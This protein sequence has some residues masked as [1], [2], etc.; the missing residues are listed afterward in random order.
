MCLNLF[1][2][3]DFCLNLL[4]RLKVPEKVTCIL[5]H[6]MVLAW[7]AEVFLR[8]KV[9]EVS[10]ASGSPP[11]LL[12]LHFSPT[13]QPKPPHLKHDMFH[14][15]PS[16]LPNPSPRCPERVLRVPITGA[17]PTLLIG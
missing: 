12:H 1:E 2:N 4:T 9:K 17:P 15:V 11:L 7:R 3:V 6:V 16:L 10:R 8:V 5:R 13:D 14:R